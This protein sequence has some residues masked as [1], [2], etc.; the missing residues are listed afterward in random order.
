MTAQSTGSIMVFGEVVEDVCAD[1]LSSWVC[2]TLEW[3]CIC[4]Y[5]FMDSN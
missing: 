2:E 3:L 1:Y 5:A 4:K